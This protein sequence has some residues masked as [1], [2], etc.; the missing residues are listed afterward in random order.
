MGTP[1]SKATLSE[2]QALASEKHRSLT[3]AVRMKHA[4]FWYNDNS[5]R[6]QV[7]RERVRSPMSLPLLP[8]K[9]YAPPP[10]ANLIQRPLLTAKL[11]MADLCPLTLIAAPAGFGKTTLVSEWIHD[12]RVTNYDLRGDSANEQTVIRNS[13]IINPAVA[14]LSLEEDDNEVGRFLSYLLFALR[15]V[16][17]A[18]LGEAVLALLQSPQP[19]PVR[20]ILNTL[21]HD[22][23]NRLQPCVLVLDDYHVIS[24]QPIHEAVIFLLDHVPALR[25]IITTRADPALPLG[26]LRARQ[27]LLELRAA[28]LR[29]SEEETNQLLNDVMQ[30]S[31][32]PDAVQE[33]QSKTE[34]WIAGLQLAGL[35]M[36]ST[37]DRAA[38]VREFYG[39]HRFVADYL[40]D[41]VLTLLPEDVQDFLLLTSILERLCAELCDAVV[42]EQG[43]MHQSQ[44]RLEGLERANLFLIPLD[45]NRRWYRYHHLFADLLRQRLQR[46]HPH[47]V[48]KLHRCA[49]R[50][51]AHQGELDDAIRHQIAGHDFAQAAD[52]LEQTQETLWM[53]GRFVMLQQWLA[54]LPTP[55]ITERPRLILA[56]AWTY[57]LTDGAATTITALFQQAETAILRITAGGQATDQPTGPTE[58]E[59]VLA[60]IRAVYYSKHEDHAGALT[61]AQRALACLPESVGSWR[62]I[63]LLSLGFAYEMQGEV[64][65]A[66][67]SFTEAIHLCHAIGNHYSALVATRSLARTCLVQGQLH[68]AATICTQG[69]AAA[70]QRGMGQL[71][72]TAHF[73]INLGRLHYEWNELAVAAEQLQ[74][75]LAILQGHSG[76]WLQFD[77]Y[78]LLARVKQAQGDQAA[79][80]ALLQQAEQVAQTIPFSWTKGA[81]AGVLVRTRLAF[82]QETGAA[83]WLTQTQPTLTSDLNRL[84]ESEQITAASVLIAQG[85]SAEAL[86]LLTQLRQAAEAAG[87]LKMVVECDVLAAVA[88]YRQGDHAAAQAT[89]RKALT[90][91]EPEGYLRTFVDEGEPMRFLILDFGFWIAQQPDTDQN[92]KLQLYVDKVL[93]A[94]TR[95]PAPETNSLPTA[96]PKI[97][98]SKSKIQNL[99]EP[100]SDRERELL[101]LM[102]AGLSNQEIADRLFITLGTVK[103]HANHIFGKLGVQGRVKAINRARELALL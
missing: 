56:Q 42:G 79:A 16:S 25:W 41:E 101:H 57:V 20:S 10:R 35:A 8:T 97:E 87:R 31:L 44:A 47:L 27:Q 67:Q 48:D 75:G 88:H 80:A 69:L 85:R 102:A 82:G 28:D 18:D 59:G 60:A 91:A 58:L 45:G 92:R 65:A 61:N 84:R 50:W 103:S 12:L 37:T 63:A 52:L 34:G 70:M 68:A 9:L 72:N 11:N 66:Y 83:Q 90:L 86:P 38:F 2:P 6:D 77:G 49:A 71:P 39:S 36:Q 96:P 17:V 3:L 5:D 21:A 7:L 23:I 26:R 78:V 33:L 93:A 32:P 40:V 29:F 43:A 99:V 74:R 62:S 73:A 24:A 100:L 54:L 15:T 19:P 1:P 14:W 13:K 30:L 46:R 94:F 81:A 95:E 89:L 51:F 55:I 64:R 53:Q 98:N 22:L 4:P 76:S